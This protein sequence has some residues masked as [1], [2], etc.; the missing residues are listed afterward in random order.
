MLAGDRQELLNTPP[1]AFR[2]VTPN[3]IL[4]ETP[5]EVIRQVE[6]GRGFRVA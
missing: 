5:V 4:Q 3:E 1:K 6:P 2:I